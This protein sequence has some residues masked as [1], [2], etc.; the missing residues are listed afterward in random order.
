[1][2]K[3]DH[4]VTFIQQKESHKFLIEGSC[5][6]VEGNIEKDASKSVL[7]STQV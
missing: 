1:M 5:G 3:Q 6:L 7:T 2:I 4:H